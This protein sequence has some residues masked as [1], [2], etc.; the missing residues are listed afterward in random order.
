MKLCLLEVNLCHIFTLVVL[1]VTFSYEICFVNSLS[2]WIHL[3]KIFYLKCRDKGYHGT[4]CSCGFYWLKTSFRP[5]K[6]PYKLMTFKNHKISHKISY[7]TMLTIFKYESLISKLGEIWVIDMTLSIISEQCSPLVCTTHFPT[8]WPDYWPSTHFLDNYFT[9]NAKLADLTIG[10]W[11][12][13][14]SIFEWNSSLIQSMPNHWIIGHRS[15]QPI[16]ETILYFIQPDFRS[17]TT[18]GMMCQ[19]LTWHDMWILMW[20]DRSS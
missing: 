6:M 7:F 16:D 3:L 5:L 14:I 9:H 13:T 10:R 11:P 1:A 15:S 18:S 17:S 4:L 8:C 19:L 12:S 2:H 20:H